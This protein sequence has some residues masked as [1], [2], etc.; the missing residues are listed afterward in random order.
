LIQLFLN[1]LFWFAKS[2]A[3]I[4]DVLQNS[5]FPMSVENN[6]QNVSLDAFR[7]ELL[8]SNKETLPH[9]KV[10]HKTYFIATPGQPFKIRYV[11]PEQYANKE[12]VANCKVDAK[13]IG[14]CG[15][16]PQNAFY[17]FNEIFAE[18]EWR[19]LCFQR[20]ERIC[21]EETIVCSVSN[22]PVHQTL[23]KVEA[24]LAKFKSKIVNY[25]EN[26]YSF[27]SQQ[28]RIHVAKEKFFNCPEVSVS[29]GS[30]LDQQPSNTRISMGETLQQSHAI[31]YYD[32]LLNLEARKI[33]DENNVEHCHLFKERIQRKAE[34]QEKERILEEK[35]RKQKEAIERK[36]LRIAEAADKRA[37]IYRIRLQKAEAT[38]RKA[39]QQIISAKEKNGAEDGQIKIKK[40]KLHK[41]FDREYFEVCDLTIGEEE[42]AT[43]S[44]N[45]PVAALLAMNPVPP[46]WTKIKRP[47][48]L[49]MDCTV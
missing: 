29:G 18:N 6:N 43:K 49:T 2:H 37:Q 33:I 25:S 44:S 9:V 32:T 5:Q 30:L 36:A 16:F 11:F 19:E 39:D 10:E 38:K 23:G 15:L 22:P 35:S 40:E 42:D 8:N 20:N 34:I 46:M 48:P 45:S 3:F 1:E 13:C 27:S 12:L 4:L 14:Y 7:V 21:T 47:E 31:V 17:L 24:H 28:K 26:Q 41:S